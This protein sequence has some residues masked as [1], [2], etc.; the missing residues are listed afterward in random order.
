MRSIQGLDGAE[1]HL[2]QEIGINWSNIDKS[3]NWKS[4]TKCVKGL[5]KT[6]LAHNTNNS[7]LDPIQYGGTLVVI[8]GKPVSW[9]LEKG[10]DSSGLG[11]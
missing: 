7:S 8:N 3:N 9:G 11:R 5:L 6:Q 10:K 4:R 2:Y 1:V